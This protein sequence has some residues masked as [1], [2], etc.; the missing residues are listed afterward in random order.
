ML[1]HIPMKIVS[2]GQTGADQGALEAAKILGIPTGGF[3]PKG[4]LTEDG[5][6]LRLRDV[7]GLEE[8]D[9]DDWTPRTKANVRFSHGTLIFGDVTGY[10]TKFTVDTCKIMGRPYIINPNTTEFLEW[11]TTY[12]IAIL[13]V[14]GNRESTARG[15][16]AHTKQF[17]ISAFQTS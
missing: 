14:A 9:S 5:P 8:H 2:G 10:G 6:D 13:N 15:L 12:N 17:L 3:A 1:F 7:Y 16:Q 4:F 11:M